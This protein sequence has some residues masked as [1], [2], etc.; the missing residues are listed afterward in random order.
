MSRSSRAF[1]PWRATGCGCVMEE[2]THGGLNHNELATIASDLA[3]TGRKQVG[4]DN[5]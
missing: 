2:E 4:P 1:R 3:D 5:D